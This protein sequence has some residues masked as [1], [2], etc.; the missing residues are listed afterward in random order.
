MHG[1]PRFAAVAPRLGSDR[2]QG[3]WPAVY[4]VPLCCSLTQLAQERDTVISAMWSASDIHEHLSLCEQIWTL[5][6]T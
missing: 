3:P 6:D 4:L 2:L 5:S 1:V